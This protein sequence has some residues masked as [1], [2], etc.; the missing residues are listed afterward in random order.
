MDLDECFAFLL[1]VSLRALI[2]DP[3]DLCAGRW[4]RD[5]ELEQ[6]FVLAGHLTV[7]EIDHRGGHD[8]IG[9]WVHSRGLG[10]EG[11]EARIKPP[12]GGGV[13]FRGHAPIQHE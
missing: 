8:S 7:R 2:G 11:D 4:D 3:V 10:V 6:P 5:V 13:R 12:G 9:C 1:T